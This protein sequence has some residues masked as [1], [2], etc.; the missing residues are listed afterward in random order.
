M[1]QDLIVTFMENLSQKSTW[2]L[3]DLGRFGRPI[4]EL[5]ISSVSSPTYID[6]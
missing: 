6:C 1:V 4:E 3:E 2:K 5:N